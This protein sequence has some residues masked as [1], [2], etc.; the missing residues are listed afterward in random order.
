MKIGLSWKLFGVFLLN[1][2]LII[3]IIASV[4]YFKFTRDFESYVKEFEQER[5]ESLASML[6]DEYSKNQNWDLVQNSPKQWLKGLG[7][8]A[9]LLH[10]ETPITAPPKNSRKKRKRKERM[11]S[12]DKRHKEEGKIDERSMLSSRDR[13]INNKKR[14]KLVERCSFNRRT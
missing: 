7:F 12:S 5:F 3:S 6:E 13:R 1:A 10:L 14:R 8:K 2:A 9:P 11:N 4:I